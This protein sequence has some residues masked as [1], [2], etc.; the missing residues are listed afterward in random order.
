[1]KSNNMKTSLLTV[2]ILSLLC[3]GA[4]PDPAQVKWRP[5]PHK[6]GDIATDSDWVI[7]P[8]TYI[9]EVVTSQMGISSVRDLPESGFKELREANARWCTGHYYTCPAGKRP[10][11]I[12]AVYARRFGRLRVERQGNSLAVIWGS[13][14][15]TSNRDLERSA[16]VVNLDFTPDEVY[17]ESSTIPSMP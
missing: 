17:N 2:L 14:P 15:G 1:M 5:A 12:R 11:L 8:K 3:I 9:Y 13:I 4:Q 10:F 7:L 16:L 6:V